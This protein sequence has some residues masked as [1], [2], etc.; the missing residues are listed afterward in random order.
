MIIS[1]RLGLPIFPPL[2][3]LGEG[4]IFLRNRGTRLRR[5][6]PASEVGSG[7]S[8]LPEIHSVVLGHDSEHVLWRA[9]D[10][11]A[12]SLG[13]MISLQY[14][15][16]KALTNTLTRRFARGMLRNTSTPTLCR[17][18][19]TENDVRVTVP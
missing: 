3:Y 17:H 1:Y 8:G 2:L 12:V 7:R 15:A 13:I 6:C 19:R 10:Q 14:E 16:E 11:A 4:V 9:P 18:A 5:G